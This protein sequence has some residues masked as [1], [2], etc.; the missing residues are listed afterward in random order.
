MNID[1]WKSTFHRASKSAVVGVVYVGS[2]VSVAE[3]S[4]RA[5]RIIVGSEWSRRD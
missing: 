3:Q 5:E 1:E 4:I 2:A